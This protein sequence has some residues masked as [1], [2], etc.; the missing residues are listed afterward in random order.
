MTS[1]DPSGAATL[2]PATDPQSPGSALPPQYSPRV[3]GY[4]TGPFLDPRVVTP[5]G[6][7]WM[8]ART[9]LV[10]TDDDILYMA[11]RVT[12]GRGHY[13][14]WAIGPILGSETNH[15]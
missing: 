4:A 2:S 9:Y 5:T 10:E 1:P 7:R 14:W 3:A 13:G 8:G 11:V 12:V 6:M 15:G